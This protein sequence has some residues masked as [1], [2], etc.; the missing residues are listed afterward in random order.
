MIETS[1]VSE[2]V[3]WMAQNLKE[4][5]NSDEIL[6]VVNECF[7]NYGVDYKFK[8]KKTDT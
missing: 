7:E 6:K 5:H 4:C 2:D 1:L 3:K 8:G